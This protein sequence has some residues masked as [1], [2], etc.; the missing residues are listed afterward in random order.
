MS[1]VHTRDNWTH[2]VLL[3]ED[4]DDHHFIISLVLAFSLE[5]IYCP[6]RLASY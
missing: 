4:D 1:A 5:H 6:R 3:Y 2:C